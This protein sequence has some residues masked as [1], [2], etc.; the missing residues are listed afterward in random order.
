M[1]NA[2]ASPNEEIWNQVTA[3]LRLKLRREPTVGEV[4]QAIRE[5]M[6]ARMQKGDL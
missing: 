6:R 2:P 5:A 1:A 3:Q 4:Y